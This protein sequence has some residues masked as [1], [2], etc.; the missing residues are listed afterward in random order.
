[1]PGQASTQGLTLICQPLVVEVVAVSMLMLIVLQSGEAG[2]YMCC[3]VFVP[4]M[5]GGELPPGLVTARVSVRQ[6]PGPANS[7]NVFKK[8]QDLFYIR[9]R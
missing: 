7:Y 5:M 9:L 6:S 4:Q 1:M 8:I 2:T 3:P